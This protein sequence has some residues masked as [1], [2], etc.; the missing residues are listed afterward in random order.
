M[1]GDQQITKI[2]V[3]DDDHELLKLIGMLLGRIG[4]QPHLFLN[5]REAVT[6]L[7]NET[8]D[9]IILD[10]MLPD[11]D[12]L[13]LLRQIRAQSRFDNIP[14]LILSAKA[15][16]A[17]IGKGLGM[18]AD[19]YVTKPYIANTLIDRVRLLLS[20]GRQ[21]RSPSDQPPPPS[22]SN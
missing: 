7:K 17:T 2:V 21:P 19:A 3:V 8:P 14:V 20:T 4:A 10:L 22:P 5:G 6:F 18:G 12:G 1:S 9:L 16:P 11:I 13:E 15:D